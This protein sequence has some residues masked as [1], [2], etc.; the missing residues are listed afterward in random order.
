MYMH[1][2]T[3]GGGPARKAAVGSRCRLPPQAPWIYPRELPLGSQSY[4]RKS[5]LCMCARV[6]FV[7]LLSV[8]VYLHV[9]LSIDNGI[10]CPYVLPPPSPHWSGG[11]DR[12]EGETQRVQKG[13]HEN[14]E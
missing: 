1:V 4:S 13:E 2:Y 14:Y 10:D 6:L 9:Y 11:R 3:G 5:S 12:Q 7:Y 8:N